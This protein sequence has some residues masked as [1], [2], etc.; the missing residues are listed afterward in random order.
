M[1]NLTPYLA[2]AVVVSILLLASGIG[3]KSRRGSQVAIGVLLLL[4]GGGAFYLGPALSGAPAGINAV[5]SEMSWRASAQDRQ[6]MQMMGELA[7]KLATYAPV[8]Y[9][10]G[11]CFLGLGAANLA[12]WPKLK[13]SRSAAN[14]LDPAKDPIQTGGNSS[15]TGVTKIEGSS[16]IPAATQSRTCESCRRVYPA[17]DSETFCGDCGS[18]LP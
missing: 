9:M 13:T 6:T 2:G 1:G 14:S 17:G 10:L 12:G 5:A 8:L 15:G 7:R 18:H 4:A 16:N 11:A 3:K